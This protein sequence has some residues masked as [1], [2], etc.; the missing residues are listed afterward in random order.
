MTE[1]QESTTPVDAGSLNRAELTEIIELA[2]WAGQ[3]LMNYGAE[4][5]R[6]EETIRVIGAG[7]GC[8][9]SNVLVSHNAILVTYASGDDFRTKLRRTRRGGV[10]MVLLEQISH[11]T[12]RVE[13]GKCDRHQLR[14]ELARIEGIPRLYNRLTTVVAIGLACAAFSR[15]FGGDWPVF[16]V[17]FV[18]AS[19]ALLARQEMAKRGFNP[20]LV[21]VAT[22]FTAGTVVELIYAGLAFSPHPEPALAAAVLLLVPGVPF[23]NAVE[24]LI[25]GYT[26][27][28]IARATAALLIIVGIALGLFLATHLIGGVTL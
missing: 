20:L 23:I 6:V 17:T 11:M 13:E 28:G 5:R 8:D 9:W 4:S 3:L 7:L 1:K 2:V 16:G 22:A 27:T 10:N 21:V 14:E 12:H 18:A 24:D 26:V 15:L 25:K 19:L